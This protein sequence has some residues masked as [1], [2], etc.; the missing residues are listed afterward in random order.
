[1]ETLN[2][3]LEVRTNERVEKFDAMPRE[4]KL[5]MIRDM[6]TPEELEHLTNTDLL[7]ILNVA[8]RLLERESLPPGQEVED[9]LLRGAIARAAAIETLGTGQSLDVYVQN[10]EGQVLSGG[11]NESEAL[12]KARAIVE[13]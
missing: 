8:R 12:K 9:A 5:K 1:M 13:E 4:A 11:R 7:L 3:N 6:Y 10:K 2:N